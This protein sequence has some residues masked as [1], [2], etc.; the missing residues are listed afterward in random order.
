LSELIGP[1]GGKLHTG[2][3][4]ND[5]VATDT[6]LWLLGEVKDTEDA[7]RGLISTMVERAEK[8]KDVIMPG[9]THLQV[10]YFPISATAQK[11]R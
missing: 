5:Q 6:R 1:L 4:R 2:R 3:S 11:S 7:L 9:Y 10:I 8:E